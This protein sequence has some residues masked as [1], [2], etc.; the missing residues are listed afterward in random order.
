MTF[1]IRVSLTKKGLQ[2]YKEVIL[3]ILKYIKVIQNKAINKRYLEEEKE[4][5]QTE[6]DYR[7]KLNPSLATEMYAKSLMN[8]DIEDVISGPYL[9]REFDESLIRK[10]L[11]MLTL[12]NL[13]IYFKSN[14]FEK[15]FNLVEEYYG[16][17]YCKEKLNITE[18]EINSYKCDHIFDYP[19]ENKFIPKNFDLLPPPEKISKYPEKIKSHK[20]I[21]I[22][23]LQ[24]TKFKVPKA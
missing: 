1:L 18:D 3:R 16:T 15:E 23:H 7:E 6:F 20:N 19:P 11:D 2:N 12:D 9:F 24:D 13:N 10:Y 17:K 4:I 8:Y 22:W 14:S 21:E 5:H